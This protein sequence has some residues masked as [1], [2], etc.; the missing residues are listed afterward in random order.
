MTIWQPPPWSGGA[1]QPFTARLIQEDLFSY[2]DFPDA[3]IGGLV[4][5]LGGVVAVT[6][7]YLLVGKERLRRALLT[8]T[9]A[10]IARVISMAGPLI[11]VPL[12]LRYLG[13][14][15]YGL[16]MTVTAMVGMF[17]FADLGLGNGLMTEV[18]QAEGKGEADR[19]L[20]EGGLHLDHVPSPLRGHRGVDVRLGD[21]PE[22]HGDLL[23]LKGPDHR[24]DLLA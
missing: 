15:R 20:E 17:T 5:L 24:A 14:E 12:A 4:L 19:A 1:T 8:S 21:L 18:S 7:G 3:A 13:H 6:I 22:A 2:L 9:S 16:W 11:T 10:V 23:W